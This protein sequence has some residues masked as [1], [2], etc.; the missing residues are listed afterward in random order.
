IALTLLGFAACASEPG[1]S[2]TAS[3]S[4]STSD[5]P[6]RWFIELKNAPTADGGD[7]ALLAA[8]RAAFRAA[9]KKAGLNLKERYV[10]QSLFNGFSVD[11]DGGSGGALQRIPGVQR[12]YPVHIV[13][14][15]SPA[16]VPDTPDQQDWLAMTGA[17]IAQ[18]E[19]GL[20]GDG[21]RVAVMD[22]GIDYLHPDL[23]GCFGPGCRV[24]KG[25]DLVGDAYDARQANPIIL[26]DP[27][28]M[29]CAGHGTHVS[30]I[31]GADG[32]GQAGHVTGVAPHV[33]FHAY[34]V[35]GCVGSTSDDIM[36]AAME[37]TLADGADVLNMS[38]GSAL[39]DWSE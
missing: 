33:T 36:L 2:S 3:Q 32:H 1:T 5:P 28:P 13:D 26:P 18:N 20:H 17:D 7:P 22:T 15:P 34:R 14:A 37:M 10:Y 4:L 29:D 21:V 23:G 38:N 31:V 24:E 19:L 9:V 39:D 12:I 25:F 16:L 35:F 6:S 11:L 8:D 30:G 27:D